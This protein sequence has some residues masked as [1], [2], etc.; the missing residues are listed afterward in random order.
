M[1]VYGDPSFTEELGVLV[2]RLQLGVTELADAQAPLTLER[3]RALL[4][5]AGQVEQA[6]QDAQ[7]LFPGGEG[8]RLGQACQTVTDRLAAAFY[9]CWAAGGVGGGSPCA[10]PEAMHQTLDVLG[11]FAPVPKGRVTVKLPEGY[12]FYKLF[13]EQ[14]AEAAR[15][16][17]AGHK[18]NGARKALIVGVRSI[19]TSLS[20]LVKAV[21]EA[22]G[23]RVERV[24]VRPTGQPY[25]RR[26]LL[27]ALAERKPDWALAVDEG[28]GKSGSSLAAAAQA[29]ADLG[30][31]PS[32]IC[33]FPGH[34]GEPGGEASEAVRAWW[35]QTPRFVVPPAALRWG[36][37]SLTEHLAA[38]TQAMIGGDAQGTRVEDFGGGLWRRF[39]YADLSDW[40]AVCVPFERPKYRCVSADGAALLWSY[41]GLAVGPEGAEPDAAF[42]R[43][44]ARA[45]AGWT[46]APLAA[47]F[48]FVATPWVVGQPL[49]A[50]DAQNGEVMAHLGRY[51]ASVAGP[52]LHENARA[53]AVAC[54]GEMLYWNV[55]KAWGEA[56][57][58]RTHSARETAQ[59]WETRHSAPTYGDGRMAPHKWLRTESGV[60]LKT[61]GGGGHDADH[62]LVGRQSVLWDV[63]G[64]LVEWGLSEDAAR[65]LLQAYQ[66]AGGTLA[67]PDVSAFYRLAYAAFRYGQCALCADMPAHDPQEQARLWAAMKRYEAEVEH[68]LGEGLLH[69]AGL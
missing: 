14:A 5:E 16:W 60:L 32:R 21:L 49:S 45:L 9:Q 6:T 27:P 46:P 64:A 58:A 30:M 43:Q 15:R 38:Q 62:T 41:A 28:P 19:G 57:A 56:G 37:Q 44:Q 69:S 26:A 1:L 12:A 11:S 52:P 13:P 50:G 55:R 39:V 42:R 4:I 25:E 51:I 22:E 8:A 33:F 20:A 29:L 24:T 18:N 48:G 36:G 63:A 54:L 40:P 10:V 61:D 67:P 47:A 66:G 35:G 17:A 68:L 53:Q 23:W 34:A 3:L 7:A 31:E 2:A 65:P 59:D